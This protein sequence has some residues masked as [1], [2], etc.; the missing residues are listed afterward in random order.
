[1]DTELAPTAPA[2]AAASLA[3]PADLVASAQAFARA[4]NAVATQ[5]AYRADWR[6]FETWCT[7]RGL[8]SLPAGGT[9]VAL[10]L[11]ARA[12]DGRRVAT[13]ARS[14]A[15]IT[16]AH[17]AAGLASPV[18]EAAVRE[19]L[20]GIRRTRGV[21]QRQAAPLLPGQLRTMVAALPQDLRGARDR[22]LLLLGFAGAFR[23]SELV[24]LD[25]ED[26]AAVDGGLE[27]TIR[28]SKTDQEGRG[29][30]VGVPRGGEPATCPVRA[31]RTWLDAGGLS[32]GPVF[33][34]IRGAGVGAERLR[35]YEVVRSVKRAAEAAG[36]DAS[37]LSGHSLRA[38]LVTAAAK[39][40]K[41]A[42]VIMKQTGHRSV[43]MVNRY[44]RDADLFSDNAA[45]GI[46]L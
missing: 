46:G 38:G 39:A 33:R 8:A 28:R 29:R 20:K 4:A 24:A 25:V 17:K 27:V 42:H 6:A 14:L 2:A 35:P 22:A 16:W 5:R 44:T 7:S 30:K 36:L 13:L 11:S 18:R 21:A 32:T 43:A 26:L 15:A 19:V 10:Y 37:L 23:R 41:P 34:R 40:G 45:K 9:T 12:D 1:M 31:V 3:V